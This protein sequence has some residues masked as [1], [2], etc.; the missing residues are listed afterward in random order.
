MRSA[1]VDQVTISTATQ[2][3]AL[4]LGADDARLP[5]VEHA[6]GE[7]GY[8]LDRLAAEA[9]DRIADVAPHTTAAYRRALWIVIALNVGYG[10]IEMV[11]G[12]LTGS[13]ALKADALDF[14]GDGLITFLGVLAIGWSLLWR[15][16]S[17]LVQGVF[18]AVL[19]MGVTGN[20]LWR[21]FSQQPIEA[22]LMGV[23]AFIALARPDRGELP[24]CF[25]GSERCVNLINQAVI[26]RA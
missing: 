22:G 25:C 12:F 19:G 24:T 13:Q 6:I 15:A 2:I 14:L 26:S 5:A 20:T 11:G 16:R 18:L 9:G 21:V 3:L 17:A 1:G 8:H 23:L 7:A 10:V 4:D